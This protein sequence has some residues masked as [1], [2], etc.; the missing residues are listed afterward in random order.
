MHLL[1][2]LSAFGLAVFI[3]MDGLGVGSSVTARTHQS[4]HCRWQTALIQFLLPPLLLLVTA[5]AIL[6]MGPHGQMVWLWEGWWSYA[7]AAGFLGGATLLSF[8]LVAEGWSSLQRV[9]DYPRL[10][11]NGQE[12]RYLDLPIPYAAQIGFW[13]SELVVSQ[14]LLNMLNPEQLQA[15]LVHEQAHHHFRDTF[16]FFWLGWL[17]RLTQ[18][19]P[20]TE[21]LWQELLVLR[22]LRADRWASQRVDGLVLAESLYLMTTMPQLATDPWGVAFA[23]MV[24]GDRLMERI[25]A[26]LATPEPDPQPNP[27]HWSELLLACLPLIAVPFHY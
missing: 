7:L 27:L 4:W 23:D 16:W 2:I 26:L 22:E 12:G 14:G 6:W 11:L 19:L 8:Q 3:R 21:A 20:Q 1:I 18:W 10:D 24:A 15:V 13:Q 5:I 17:R 25:N 9:R